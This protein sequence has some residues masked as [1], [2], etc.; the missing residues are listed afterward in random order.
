MVRYSP[1]GILLLIV[2]VVFGPHD[3]FFASNRSQHTQVPPSAISSVLPD[4][5]SVGDQPRHGMVDAIETKQ[6]YIVR[7]ES[8]LPLRYDVLV[9]ILVLA[10]WA[11]RKMA[12]QGRQDRS[13]TDP[14]EG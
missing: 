6:G 1:I 7:T 11:Y 9:M 14:E 4:A 3:W 2:F 8:G 13:D 5:N 12:V 10:Y